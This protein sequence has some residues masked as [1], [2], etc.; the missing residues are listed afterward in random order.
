M[1]RPPRWRA[2]GP[3]LAR[4]NPPRNQRVFG[5]MVGRMEI[6]GDLEDPFWTDAQWQQFERE[7]GVQWQAVENAQRVRRSAAKET[8]RG[9]RR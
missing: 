7:R 1:Q 2:V 9:T 3:T 5:C 6:V 4:A 8:R